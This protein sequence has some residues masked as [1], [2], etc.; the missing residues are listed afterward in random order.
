VE[1]HCLVCVEYLLLMNVL[2]TLFIGTAYHN[3]EVR[4][5]DFTSES[6]SSDAHVVETAESKRTRGKDEPETDPVVLEE[7]SHIVG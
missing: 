3:C 7:L 1:I 5:F 4:I 6:T 2:L